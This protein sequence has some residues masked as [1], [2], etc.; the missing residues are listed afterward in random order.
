MS[1]ISVLNQTNQASS[2][3]DITPHKDIKISSTKRKHT[4]LSPPQNSPNAKKGPYEMPNS[5]P[6]DPNK[7]ITY[8]DLVALLSEQTNS[9]T[10]SFINELAAVRKEINDKIDEKLAHITNE[11]EA[12][13]SN[14]QGQLDE[15]K[16]EI[17]KQQNRNDDDYLRLAK[18]SELKIKGIEHTTNENLYDIVGAIANAVNF[19]LNNPYNIPSIER[20][21]KYNPVTKSRTPAPVIILK[22]I[23]NH[24]RDEF[25][26]QY[27]SKFAGKQQ[28]MTEH[29][30]LPPGGRIIVGESLTQSNYA[31]FNVASKFKRENKISQVFTKGGL[32]QIKINKT[33]RPTVI[34]SIRQLELIIHQGKNQ[35][36]TSAPPVTTMHSVATP[37][38]N[39]H[40]VPM[41]TSN[42]TNNGTRNQS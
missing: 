18:S 14:V 5:L 4:S 13:K 32:V 41:E 22:F 7:P 16:N 11:I 29:I 3:V 12:V 9:L 8:N 20:P 17:T 19:N 2:V 28:F 30:G 26:S 42:I 15:M 27:L 21:Y 38:S 23:A 40:T 33:D 37:I 35:P 6:A 34:R 39:Q 10:N 24:I 31:I 1:N 36:S 25:Y